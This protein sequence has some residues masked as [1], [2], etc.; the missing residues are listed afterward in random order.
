MT[1]NT[2]NDNY[3][4]IY[5]DNADNNNFTS[6]TVK[7]NQQ[8][9][10]YALSTSTGNILNLNTFCSN[11][12]SAG[13]YYDIYDADSNSGDN[14]TCG[15]AYNWNDAGV[16][17]CIYTCSGL[18]K[19]IVTKTIGWNLISIN[20]STTAKSF[21]TETNCTLISKYEG[22]IQTH[23]KG[24]SFLNFNVTP[25]RGYYTYCTETENKTITGTPVE[26]VTVPLTTGWNLIGSVSAAITNASALR[27][28]ISSSSCIAVSKYDGG[29]FTTYTGSPN[30]DFI[31]LQNRGYF[32]YLTENT[33]WRI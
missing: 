28:N 15:T 9:G 33:D 27:T 8:H 23:I 5:L 18:S 10:F 22:G 16:T 19:V 6:N 29:G 24:S 30:D 11:N 3:N 20:L 25:G 13:A 2:A 7:F 4:G 21:L 26:N 32:V 14:N 1:S 31:V 17:G 12:Q